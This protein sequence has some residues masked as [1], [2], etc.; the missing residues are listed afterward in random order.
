[1]L[2]HITGRGPASG[3]EAEQV[4]D[5]Q[6]QL[7]DQPP[8]VLD[9]ELG[10]QGVRRKIAAA[11]AA[12]AEVEGDDVM[13]DGQRP[14][15]WQQIAVPD[16]GTTVQGDQRRTIGPAPAQLSDEQRHVADLDQARL[17]HPDS[18][19][20]AADSSELSKSAATPAGQTRDHE[21]ASPPQ[22]ARRQG[23]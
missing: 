6:A 21:A 19:E 4:D 8:G 7:L 17:L 5:A 12:A 1:M 13:I 15:T 23:R 10:L 20:P 3:R 16:I 11:S 22:T 18:V 9:H 14:Q 2:L